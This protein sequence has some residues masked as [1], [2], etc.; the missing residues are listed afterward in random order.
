MQTIVDLSN[1][2]CYA[3]T[4]K[5]VQFNHQVSASDWLRMYCINLVSV[6]KWDTKWKPNGM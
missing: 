6:K 3:N 4:S 1:D 5:T 2:K